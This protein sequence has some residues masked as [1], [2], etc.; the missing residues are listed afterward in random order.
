LQTC[1]FSEEYHKLSFLCT[2]QEH[3]CG[4]NADIKFPDLILMGNDNF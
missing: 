1:T 4:L 2:L 3:F